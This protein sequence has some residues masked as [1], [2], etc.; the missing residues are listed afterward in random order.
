MKTEEVT[1][2][3]KFTKWY[4]FNRLKKVFVTCDTPM[5][6]DEALNFFGVAAVI[7]VTDKEQKRDKKIFLFDKSSYNQYTID[8]LSEDECEK[9][10]ADSADEH[11]Y[12]C[13]KINANNYDTIED[14]LVAC[15]L[16]YLEGYFIKSFGF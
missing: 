7:G 13:F 5:T 1:H 11:D 12:T 4:L 15:D 2:Q 16:W 3:D 14:A 10:C 8:K 9:W 6:T